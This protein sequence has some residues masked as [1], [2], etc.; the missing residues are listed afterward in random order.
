MSDTKWTDRFSRGALA[1]VLL[2]LLVTAGGLTLARYDA[3]PK[4][5]GLYAMLIGALIAAAAFVLALIGLVMGLVHRAQSKKFALVAMLIAAAY[6]GYLGSRA[7]IARSVPP[8]HDITTD[9]ADPPSFGTL[10]LRADNLAGV[11]T[12][13]N[14]R[15]KHAEAYP[16]L[17]SVT[18]NRP[19]ET[20][21]TDAERLV[22]DRGWTVA[23]ASRGAG[24]IEATASVSYIRYQDDVIIRLRPTDEGASTIVDMRSVSRVGVSDL[25]MNAKR[26]REFLTELSAG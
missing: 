13:E 20:V 18:I 23:S 17:R 4:I 1:V 11:E 26:I 2:A 25:G 15:Q 10:T 21:F 14:W 19:P 22:R 5:D 8:L 24:Q 16:D 7:V 3:I 6:V 12:V 9:L